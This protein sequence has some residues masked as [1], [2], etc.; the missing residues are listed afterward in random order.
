MRRDPAPVDKVRP[1]T[2]LLR[3]GL[4][5]GQPYFVQ[6]DKVPRAGTHLT[7][8][9]QRTRW[10]GGRVVVRLGTHKRPVT[11]KASAGWH[12]T[13]SDHHDDAQRPAGAASVPR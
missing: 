13:N 3:E 1:L 4:D 11:A 10:Y 2:A 6:E 12:S 9:Y 7:Q 5:L 8:A